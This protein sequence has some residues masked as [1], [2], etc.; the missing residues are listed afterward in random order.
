MA[1]RSPSAKKKST[2]NSIPS[3]SILRDERETKM[4]SDDRTTGRSLATNLFLKN[5]A[6]KQ[7]GN[8]S[9]AEKGWELQERQKNLGLGKN[10]GN[11]FRLFFS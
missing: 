4:F 1:Q 3:Q 5:S 9:R 10:T 8:D 11:P 7:K 6:L 2:V